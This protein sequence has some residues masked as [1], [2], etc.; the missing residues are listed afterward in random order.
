MHKKSIE[1]AETLKSSDDNSDKEDEERT[2]IS[3]TSS[4]NNHRRSPTTPTS[5]TAPGKIS[6]KPLSNGS[7]SSS[8]ISPVTMSPPISHPPA[9][10]T[11]R[12]PDDSKGKDFSLMSS[13]TSR[14]PG[15]HLSPHDQQ[16]PSNQHPS[17]LAHHHT[18][19]PAAHHYPLNPM[20]PSPDTDPEVFRWVNY[21]RDYP[22][23]FIRWIFLFNYFDFCFETLF[24]F[25]QTNTWH[26]VGPENFVGLI[27][28]FIWFYFRNNSIACLR[29]KAQEHQARLMN[30]GLLALQVRSLAG[31]QHHQLPSPLSSSP[32]SCD[33]AMIHQHSPTPS[34]IRSPESNNNN[35]TSRNFNSSMAPSSDMSEDI[36]IEDVKPIHKTNVSPNVVTF[37]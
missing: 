15:Y 32:K 29:A 8:S 28:V 2:E 21:N 19:H 1:A 13:P 4:I 30:S 34:P 11:Q 7:P 9:T 31:L 33:S 23:S 12:I 24:A 14:A 17:A 18:T 6:L 26:L 5:T 16:P 20:N 36:D 27:L 35:H 25:K 3:D 22:V 37:W 10:P